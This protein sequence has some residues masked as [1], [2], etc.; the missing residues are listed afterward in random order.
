MSVRPARESRVAR[1]SV[2]TVFFLVG[3]GTANWAVR[4]PAVQ[5][6]LG[7]SDGQL[8]IALLGVSAGAIVAMPLSGRLVARLGSRPVTLAGSIA[9][10]CA[11]ALPALAPSLPWLLAALVALGLTNGILDV[12]MNAQAA[13]IQT[14]Y[15]KPIMGGVHAF[16]SMGGLVGAAIGGRVAAHEIP[17]S[18]H[19]GVIGV[20]VCIVAVIAATGMLPAHTDA[21]EGPARRPG[22]LRLLGAMGVLAFFVL[23]GEGAMLNWSAVYLRNVVGT[24]PGLAAAGFASFS[25]LMTAGRL[26]GDAVT[27]RLGS[28]R[29]TQIGGALAAAG[30]TLALI[31]PHPVAVVIGFGAVGAGLSIIFPIVLA[32]AARTP[33]VVPGSAIATVSMCGYA[34]L[35]AGPPLIGAVAN[36]LTLRGGL[37]LVSLTSVGVI[38]LSRVVRERRPRSATAPAEAMQLETSA[39]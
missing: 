9:F 27:S 6:A 8:G 39:A 7:L 10:A 4:I 32:A 23:F 33:G 20:I 2:S 30:V 34:G 15:S 36:V 12:A 3:V 28:A 38:L 11:L 21:V 29:V 25:L 26:V 5:S 18:T 17:V 19:L 37:A 14:G 31:A 22:Q 13:A 16:Y 35:L 24:G 1:W